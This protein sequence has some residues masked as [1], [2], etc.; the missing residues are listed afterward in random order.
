MQIPPLLLCLV[1]AFVVIPND[2]GIVGE[3]ESL[4]QV[5]RGFDTMG[6]VSLTLSVSTLI[7][8]LNLGGNI[9]PCKTHALSTS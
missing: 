7:L 9:F 8:G 3:R 1:I 5:V 2:L 4:S 6:A